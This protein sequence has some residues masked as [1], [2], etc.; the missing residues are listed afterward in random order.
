MKPYLPFVTFVS[1]SL[2][3]SL[4]AYAFSPVYVDKIYTQNTQG[5]GKD[6]FS[7]INDALQAV[8][9][10]GTIYVAEGTYN[11]TL[12]IT[13]AVSIIG[14]GKLAASGASSRAPLIYSGNATGTIIIDGT[15]AP[16]VVT[17]RNLSIG[18]GTYGIAVLKNAYVIVMNST[19]QE[20]KKNGITFGPT[21]LDGFG[22][23]QGIIQN[24]VIVGM[25]PTDTIPQNGIQ[26]AEN[27]TA[28]ITGNTITNH[29]Y[30]PAGKKWA[31]GILVHD[32]KNVLISKNTIN[33]NQTGINILQAND[34]TI[35]NNTIVGN[36]ATKAGI[37]ITNLDKAEFPTTRNTVSRNTITG[38][39]TG[40]WSSYAS[41][42]T[43]SNNTVTGTSQYGIYT[44]D[45]DNNIILS[46]IIKSVHASSQK[47]YGIALEGGDTV[48]GN[49]GSDN[50]QISKNIVLQSDAGFYSSKDS[51]N[52]TLLRNQF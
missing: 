2:A 36:A 7:T 11:E 28:R 46:N 22:N 34:N 48:T 26:I 43:I 10:G 33:Y 41:G 19:I 15:Q 49:T 3:C 20:Y 25:G 39:T 24:N 40:I 29:I 1:V 52:N 35:T 42:N 45:S 50:N 30:I 32:S 21:L 4:S 12:R 6:A 51:E 31:T 13:K 16:V 8:D 17:L 47:G 44:W 9:K 5:Y 27:N 38:G 23:I 37:L 18:G 14:N